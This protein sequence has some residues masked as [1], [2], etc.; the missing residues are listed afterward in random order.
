MLIEKRGNYTCIEDYINPSIANTKHPYK[1]DVKNAPDLLLNAMINGQ[2]ITIIGDY[3]CDGICASAISFC[4]FN[5]VKELLNQ[6]KKD[7]AL[8]PNNICKH[9][10]TLTQ[11]VYDCDIEKAQNI[12]SSNHV[13]T[14]KIRVR[15]PKRYTEGYGMKASMVDEVKSGV[16]FTVDNGIAASDAIQKAINKGLITIVTDHHSLPAQQ[17]LSIVNG[18][19]KETIEYLVPNATCLINPHIEE[20]FGQ[21]GHYDFYDY[22][23]AGVA[24]KVVES[25][26]S[27]EDNILDELY[28]FAAIATVAD[29]MPMIEDN[30]NIFERGVDA[31]RNGNITAGLAA[32]I[33]ISKLNAEYLPSDMPSCAM[34][35][36]DIMGFKFGPMIN[37]AGRVGT[38]NP[39]SEEGNRGAERALRCLLETDPSKAMELAQELNEAN[40][41]RKEISKEMQMKCDVILAE[42]HME[43]DCPLVVH[44]PECG[45]GVIGLV[46]G[47][48]C[49][50]YAVP[51]IVFNGHGE[52]C[53]GS[54]RSPE[55]INIKALLDECQ[56]TLVAYGGHPGAAGLTIF[57]N[58]IDKLRQ[59]LYNSCSRQ[60]IHSLATDK[61]QY[62]LEIDAQDIPHNAEILV[63]TLAPFGEKNPEPVFLVK[64]F[65]FYEDPMKMGEK[66]IKLK[67]SG[68]EAIGFSLA[69]NKSAMEYINTHQSV[70]LLGT[71]SYN[72]FRGKATPQLSIQF[73]VD[74]NE[75]LK[76]EQD[77]EVIESEVESEVLI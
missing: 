1:F 67:G 5:R 35:S 14:T 45:S 76:D 54:A 70:D 64:N 21:T 4:G 72:C 71:L 19:M 8:I 56:S 39:A 46:A 18:E 13:E 29:V 16:L 20:T 7:P 60:G 24:L 57:E 59:M 28:A 48:L 11:K 27:P 34:F 37:A 69:E 12:L 62:D 6:Y 15:I 65:T 58:S 3:D 33:Q 30:R 31:M 53:K 51:A 32:I 47:Y 50:K 43:Q 68:I 22:C 49:E 41:K 26:L 75:I 25:V 36:S 44:I 63:K 9:L 74:G 52:H 40:E 61:I 66:H 55:G 73:V 23:G 77:I 2:N 38:S 42:N 10:V 17:S